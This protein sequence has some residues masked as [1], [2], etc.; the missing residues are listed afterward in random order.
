MNVLAKASALA[1]F[2]LVPLASA[3]GDDDAEK[4]DGGGTPTV[5]QCVGVYADRTAAELAE[6]ST[7]GACADDT[8]AVCASDIH[9][10]AGNCGVGCATQGGDEAEQAS[11]TLTCLRSSPSPDPSDA[12]YGCYIQSVGCAYVNC[13]EQCAQNPTAPACI[14]CRADEGC[15]AGFYTCSGL[16][17]PGSAPSMAGSGGSQ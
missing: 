7:E 17:F 13:F 5:Q 2:A 10:R 1:L 12:C 11:C 16:P 4:D 8:Q 15:T 9:T 14:A 3:C 6:Q